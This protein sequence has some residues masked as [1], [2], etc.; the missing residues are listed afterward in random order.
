MAP[1]LSALTT[2]GMNDNN[3]GLLPSSFTIHGVKELTLL[4]GDQ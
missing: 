1:L 3:V 2:L 4:I